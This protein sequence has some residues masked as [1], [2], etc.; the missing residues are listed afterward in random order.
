MVKKA[1]LIEFNVSTGK[2]PGDIV[3]NDPGLRCYGWQKLDV[4]PA[5]EI[6]MI[7]DARDVS[8]YEGRSGVTILEGEAAIDAAIDALELE[9]YS[10]DSPD[11]FRASLEHK[12]IDLD[13]YKGWKTADVLK[14]LHGKKKVL[15]VRK[16]LPK[17]ASVSAVE[18]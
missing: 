6:R 13:Q 4:V 1:L 8:W 10:V 15:G 12:N 14:D 9:R 11:L 7:E 3:S 16:S 2:R 17:K 18:L 5:L